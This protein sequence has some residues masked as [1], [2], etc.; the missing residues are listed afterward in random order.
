L[1]S[2]I[3]PNAPMAGRIVTARMTKASGLLPCW[4]SRQLNPP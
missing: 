2:V 3:N 4:K 1:V